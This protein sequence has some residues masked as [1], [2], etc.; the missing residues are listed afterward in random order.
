MGLWE[1]IQSW[2]PELGFQG[3]VRAGRVIWIDSKDQLSWN[4]AGRP[5]TQSLRACCERTATTN[6]TGRNHTD[7]HGAKKVNRKRK[8]CPNIKC[9]GFT[10]D[11]MDQF[12]AGWWYH[13]PELEKQDKLQK[14]SRPA[15][16][17]KTT[18]TRDTADGEADKSYL[19]PG[20]GPLKEKRESRREFGDDVELEQPNWRQEWL[21][22]YNLSPR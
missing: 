3:T 10:W 21:Q 22:T 20:G 5:S 19:A 15:E 2:R 4:Q 13:L 16:G 12:T 8:S 1:A 9:W 14:A 7:G 6:L 18:E 17:K 11:S